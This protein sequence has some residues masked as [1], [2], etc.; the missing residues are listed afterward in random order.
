MFFRRSVL[1]V[2]VLLAAASHAHASCAPFPENKFLGSYTHEQV[3]N[4]VN[5][6][7]GGDWTPYL[8]T[9][10][11]NL[12]SLQALQ[13]S[14]EAAVLKVRGQSVQVSPSDLDR[15]VYAS[16]QWLMV[17][18]CLAEE[19]VMAALSNFPTAAGGDQQNADTAV[20]QKA[21]PVALQNEVAS[22]S[23]NPI[24]LKISTSCIAGET[25]FKV[26]N[27]GNAW[28]ST[29]TFSMFRIDGP[30]RQVISARRMRLEAGETKMLKVSKAQ[31][32]TGEVGLSID[33]SW[34]KRAF[35]IDADAKCR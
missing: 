13:K 23:I 30:N 8:V 26:I 4:Y 6:S 18:Q 9:L 11:K 10:Q 19:Q 29:G 31:N 1:A 27:A 21:T 2:L 17:A 3:K 33:P 28:P 24:K 5:K 32:M 25:T 14:D 35:N 16:R 20:A 12:E 22:L 15:Y 7:S 34:Y